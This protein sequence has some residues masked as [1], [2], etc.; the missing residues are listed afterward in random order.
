[1]AKF[2]WQTYS[3]GMISEFLQLSQKI[4][5][6]AAMATTLRLENVELRRQLASAM[7]DQAAC[8]EKMRQAQQRL[9]ALIAQLPAPEADAD[10]DDADGADD[11]E[12][13]A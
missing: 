3:D 12:E 7:G 9:A 2:D 5:Q 6:L 1:L 13:A 11:E 10:M 8:Q 4:D